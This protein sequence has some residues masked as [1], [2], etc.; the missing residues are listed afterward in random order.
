MDKAIERYLARRG[1]HVTV[2]AEGER[3]FSE[4]APR[5]F[6]WFHESVLGLDTEEYRRAFW[7]EAYRTG[8]TI[9][10]VPRTLD[11][12]LR[13]R[14]A[15]YRQDMANLLCYALL[16]GGSFAVWVMRRQI[17]RHIRRLK[18]PGYYERELARRHELAR[19]RRRLLKRSTINPCPTDDAL[20]EAFARAKGSPAAMIRFGSLLEDLE[21]HVDNSAIFDGEGNLVGRRGGIRRYLALNVPELSARYKTVMRYKALAKRFRQALGVEDPIPAAMLLPETK[22]NPAESANQ[23]KREFESEQNLEGRVWKSQKA[24]G[25][26]DSH[27]LPVSQPELK[28][29]SGKKDGREFA[30]VEN[31]KEAGD[32][33]LAAA[34]GDVLREDVLK[35]AREEA[36]RLLEG[37]EGSCVSLMAAL[38]IRISPDYAPRDEGGMRKT[39]DRMADAKFWM[40]EER[41]RIA[42]VRAGMAK[43]KTG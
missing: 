35:K 19:E 11:G 1:I 38:A 12:Y 30:S 24:K 27:E 15:A 17:D 13:R 16:M 21:C 2:P 34:R 3:P 10:H 23:G 42:R 29:N 7:R 32:V 4:R 25:R 28:R 22:G 9:G 36:E 37:C 20:R 18:R 6:A 41:R 26:M 40:A 5:F 33:A 14:G 39:A 43:V 31:L 8:R